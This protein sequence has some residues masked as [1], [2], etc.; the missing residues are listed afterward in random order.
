MIIDRST[1][2]G[3][4]ILQNKGN[5]KVG[6]VVH[7]EHYSKIPPTTPIFYGITIMSINLKTR[8][9]LISSSQHRLTE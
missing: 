9:I 7:A 2:V 6:I 3:Q 5:S 8:D 4:A 1:D